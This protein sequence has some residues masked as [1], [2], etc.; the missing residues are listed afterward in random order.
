MF[1]VS[2]QILATITANL[3]ELTKKNIQWYWTKTHEKDFNHLK[4]LL[5]TSPVLQF[6]NEQK[7]IT[8]SVDSSKD[9][10]GAVILQDKAPIA[11]ASKTLTESQKN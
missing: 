3:R 6:Y 10:I 5:S 8:L 1:H 11:Y 2:Y 4:N 9:G 7:P